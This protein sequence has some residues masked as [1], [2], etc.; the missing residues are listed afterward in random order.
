MSRTRQC[1]IAFAA[2]TSLAMVAVAVLKTD[3]VDEKPAKEIKTVALATQDSDRSFQIQAMP[4]RFTSYEAMRETMKSWASSAPEISEFAAYGRTSLGTCVNYLRVG[5]RDKPKVL[6]QSGISSDE[7]FGILA[8]LKLAER[9]LSNF[10][11]DE[12]VT[13]LVRNRDIYFVPVVSPDNF[14]QS[15]LVEGKDP[16]SSFPCLSKLNPKSPSTVKLLMDFVQKQKFSASLNFHTYG[17]HFSLP[18]NAHEKDTMAMGKIAQRMADL[19]GYR[20][21]RKQGAGNPSDLDWLYSSGCFSVDVML[22]SNDRKYVAYSEVESSM[23]RL[24][25]SLALFIREAPESSISP[26]PLPSVHFYQG[27]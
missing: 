9:I 5:T 26:V 4:D 8:N 7:E 16:E 20:L 12:A 1:L 19:S 15:N 2:T 17:E 21:Q 23:D 24:Y 14:L 10:G 27:E 22:G 13:W 6:I 11:K 18:T 3:V 25:D